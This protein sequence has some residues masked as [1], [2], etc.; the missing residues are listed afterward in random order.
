MTKRKK[1]N[2]ICGKLTKRAVSNKDTNYKYVGI[3]DEH[4]ND[5]YGRWSQKKF[6][7]EQPCARVIE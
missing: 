4:M 5:V 3:C 1:N 7:V 2:K 6:L